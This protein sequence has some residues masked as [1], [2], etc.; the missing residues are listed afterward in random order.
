MRTKRRNSSRKNA[1]VRCR[2]GKAYEYNLYYRRK[3]SVARELA[4]IVRADKRENGYIEGNGY[5]VTWAIGHLVT[6]AMPDAYGSGK[7]DRNGLPLLPDPFR[8]AVR[9]IREGKEYK[10]DP[11]AVRQLSVIKNCFNRSNAIIVATDAGREGEL[12]F[13]YIYSFLNCTNRSSGCG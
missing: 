10:D 1:D 7:F 6:L 8:L 4:N 12:I 13:R 5:I 9:Q 11:A 3:A 2:E